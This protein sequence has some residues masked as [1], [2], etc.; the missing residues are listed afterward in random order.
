MNKRL[1]VFSFVGTILV[2]YFAGV[3]TSLWAIPPRVVVVQKEVVVSQPAT[4]PSNTGELHISDAESVYVVTTTDRS[5]IMTRYSISGGESGSHKDFYL[6]TDTGAAVTLSSA[7]FS[8][9]FGVK[10]KAG[11]EHGIALEY[12]II[13]ETGDQRGTYSFVGIMVD[14]TTVYQVAKPVA[15]EFESGIGGVG[16]NSEY[17]LAKDLRHVYLRIE[18]G[19]EKQV[20]FVYDIEKNTLKKIDSIP[21]GE[22]LKPMFQP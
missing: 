9:S 8:D 12:D 6:N 18:E 20:R 5:V 21:Q 19:L 22:L 16:V 10:N 11:I 4:V 13:M 3:M 17:S 15:Y 14:K 1:L 7:S 2:S